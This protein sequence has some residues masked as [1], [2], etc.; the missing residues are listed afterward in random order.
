MNSY[1]FVVIVHPFLAAALSV[2]PSVSQ[3]VRPSASYSS[4][5]LKEEAV[6]T[7]NLVK[8]QRLTRVTTEQI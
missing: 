1:L 4:Y 5:F 7:S 3:S 8:T 2:A 6:Q